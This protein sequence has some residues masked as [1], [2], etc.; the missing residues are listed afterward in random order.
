MAKISSFVLCDAI[1]NITTPYGD[2]VPQLMAPQPVLR[3]PV[4]PSTYSFGITIGI[5]GV[6]FQANNVIRMTIISPKGDEIYN[7]GEINLG[8]IPE[9]DILPAEY[10]GFIISTDIRNLIIDCEGI[11]HASIDLNNEKVG[12]K[13]IPVFRK[14]DN[15]R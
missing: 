9:D 14:G 1:T 3:P 4:I 10:Q 5:T 2:S 15:T 11:Y 6:I 8:P 7:S 12:E 13:E